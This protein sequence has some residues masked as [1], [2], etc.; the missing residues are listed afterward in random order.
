LSPSLRFVREKREDIA[1]GN[2]CTELGGFYKERLDRAGIALRI[3]AKKDF[4]IRMNRGKLNQVLD[5]LILNSEYWLKEDLRTSKLKEA[6]IDIDIE[7]P[8]LR[9]RDNGRGFAKSIEPNLFEPF[10]TTKA[11]GVGRG[12]GLFI[13]KQLL[14]VERCSIDLLSDRNKSGNRFIIQLNMSGAL[15]GK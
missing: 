3:S 6:Y 11:K 8:F 12:L 5:N 10:V 15:S 7:K 9:V 4:S 13:V 1:L 14:E 2:F